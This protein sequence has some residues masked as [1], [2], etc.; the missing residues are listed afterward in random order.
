[1][2]FINI[3]RD[4]P[5]L[6]PPDMRDWVE[7][8][9]PVH[10]ILEVVRQ[11]PLSSFQVNQ[12]GTGSDQYPPSM[13]LAL[14]IYCYS[15]GVF[16]SRRIEKATWRDV[17]VRYLTGNT[18]P[19]HDTICAFRRKNGTAIAAC[20]AQVL[21]LAKEAG[22]TKIGTVSV[23]GTLMKANA[24]KN[25]N[26]GYERAG[27]LM[28]KL[29]ESIGKLMEKAEQADQEEQDERLPEILR[30]RKRLHETVRQA[31]E[32]MEERARQKAQQAKEIPPAQRRGHDRNPSG[33]PK[34]KDRDNLTDPDSRIMRKSQRSG[35][36][37]AYNGQAVVDA[38][39]SQ[40]ILA[41][42]ISQN[43]H[44][45]GEL[46]ADID[47]IPSEL[48]K[49]NAVV[50]DSGYACEQEVTTLE[51]RGIDTYVSVRA[52]P[53]RKYSLGLEAAKEKPLSSRA[54]SAF[55]QRMD[56]KLNTDAGKA[57]YALRKKSVE[58]VFGIIKKAMGFTQFNL[59]GRDKVE[60][61]WQLVALAYNFKRLWN[62][63]RAAEA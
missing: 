4:T 9:D 12:R 30:D 45:A 35:F 54:R 15:M 44:D 2:S 21:L 51:S 8:S 49:P 24:S 43:S 46:V 40:L 5:L 48:G 59:R 7:D 29:E 20:F 37:Q 16:G 31:R 58:P 57:L 14:L 53:P 47:A 26:V 1:M 25:K 63:K 13:M 23:D 34:P 32:R 60:L 11:I 39:G 61:E 22:V 62:I 27:E 36:E 52:E 55:G 41:A 38:E 56:A 18:H 10:F 6:F 3:D 17:G 33:V 42:R 19:D 28:E 50:A